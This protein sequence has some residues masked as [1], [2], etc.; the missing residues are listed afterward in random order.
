[1][2]KRRKH[3]TV[4]SEIKSPVLPPLVRRCEG[5]RDVLLRVPRPQ[6]KGAAAGPHR[7]TDLLRLRRRGKELRGKEM[8]PQVPVR[9]NPQKPSQTAMKMAACAIELGLKLCSSTP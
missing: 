4:V 1:L 3:P 5:G 2:R 6:L 9:V 8:G 7:H